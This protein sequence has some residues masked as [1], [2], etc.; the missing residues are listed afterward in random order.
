[1]NSYS[2]HI[3]QLETSEDLT[4]V[5]IRVGEKV[6]FKSIV[7]DTPKS[8]NYLA[9]GHKIDVI[10][11]ETEVVISTDSNPSI[12]LQNKVEGRITELLAGDL[13][14]RLVL[15]TELGSLV[16]IISTDAVKS[17]KLE[18]G[19]YVTALIKLNEITLAT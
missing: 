7:I 14:S 1:M 18:I 12:S 9:L 19:M 4:L 3:E 8:V 17:L 6:I 10:F 2:G 11:K 16:A 5:T 15:G 13:L